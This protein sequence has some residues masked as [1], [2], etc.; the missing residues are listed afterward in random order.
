MEFSDEQHDCR[1]DTN[2]ERAKA[3]S[4]ARAK[5]EAK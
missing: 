2:P 1:G 5:G 4:R 3:V